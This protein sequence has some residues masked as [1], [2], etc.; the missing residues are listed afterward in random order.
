LVLVQQLPAGL[1]HVVANVNLLVNGLVVRG[2]EFSL[3][4]DD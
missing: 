4:Y 3:A 2:F 1:F